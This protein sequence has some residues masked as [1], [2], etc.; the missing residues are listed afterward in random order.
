MGRL[1]V[2]LIVA[3][4]TVLGAGAGADTRH[5]S[6]PLEDFAQSGVTG[7]VE[8]TRMHRGGTLVTVKANGLRPGTPYVAQIHNNQVCDPEPFEET[9][10]IGRFT[11]NSVGMVTLTRKMTASLATI[12]SISVREVADGD[13]VACA[14]LRP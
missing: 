13:L 6:A 11:A 10:V 14:N 3:L 1:V 9:R 12:G 4:L 8:A 7:R 2:P 5:V